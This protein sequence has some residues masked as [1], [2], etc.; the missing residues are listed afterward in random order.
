MAGEVQGSEWWP[1]P[2]AGRC[3]AAVYSLSSWWCFHVLS[4]NSIMQHLSVINWAHTDSQEGSSTLNSHE[5]ASASVPWNAPR[6]NTSCFLE[7]VNAS[8]CWP[9]DLFIFIY[10]TLLLLLLPDLWP[11]FSF[12][13]ELHFRVN[14]RYWSHYSNRLIHRRHFDRSRQREH[15]CE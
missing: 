11:F 2:G 3:V 5:W 10:P 8:S 7:A 9:K 12:F 4:D 6:G 14:R 15:K 1:Q 13:S